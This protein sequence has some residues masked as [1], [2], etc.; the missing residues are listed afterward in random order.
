MYAGAGRLHA[1]TV[2]ARHI[3]EGLELRL[4][5]EFAVLCAVMT[6]YKFGSPITDS[7]GAFHSWCMSSQ[8]ASAIVR[9]R[10]T[11]PTLDQRVLKAIFK[12]VIVWG[13]V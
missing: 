12:N 6:T 9:K 1:C 5:I 2:P 10:A 11:D 4:I 13:V 7:L 3:F 8:S